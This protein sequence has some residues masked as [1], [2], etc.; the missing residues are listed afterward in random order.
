ME[1]KRRGCANFYIN[2]LAEEAV[3]LF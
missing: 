1:Y 2:G 3:A